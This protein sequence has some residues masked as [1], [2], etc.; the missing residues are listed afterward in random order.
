MQLK[1]LGLLMIS[2]C[3]FLGPS[4]SVAAQPQSQS[5]LLP[6][7][8]QA[9]TRTADPS[10]MLTAG[11]KV[12]QLIDQGLASELWPHVSS[13][14]KTKITPE[15][16]AKGIYSLR[17]P[18]G[19]VLQRQWLNISQHQSLANDVDIPAGLYVDV[20]FLTS[21]EGRSAIEEHVTFV[22]DSDNVW[23]IAGYVINPQ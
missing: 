16:F 11:I 7:T 19:N 4:L 18:L 9:T 20:T 2:A 1:K 8:Q 17:R 10:T 5:G 23:R 15:N 22:L 13:I 3:I 6:L 21:F 12:L 14:V